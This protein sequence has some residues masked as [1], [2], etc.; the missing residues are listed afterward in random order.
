MNAI[1]WYLLY[2]VHLIVYIQTSILVYLLVQLNLK[3]STF[4]INSVIIDT[5]S[6]TV[7][8]APSTSSPL[9][10]VAPASARSSVDGW[11]DLEDANDHEENGSDEDGWDDV[12]PFE[13]KSSPS[14]LSNIQ[15]APKRPAVQP[16]QAGMFTLVQC[17][18]SAQVIT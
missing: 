3:R 16:K 4:N 1:L 9:D 5:Q 8:Y 12:D 11:D 13:D 7:A 15:A 18:V 6:A 2:L 14:L 10:Q 17:I